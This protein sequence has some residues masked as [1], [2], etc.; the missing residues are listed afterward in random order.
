MDTRHLLFTILLCAAGLAG[1][2]EFQANVRTA[3]NQCHPAIA[4][5]ADGRC[6]L[7]WS[8]Y[9]SS[10]GRSNDIVARHF[11]PNGSPAGDELQL[12]ATRVGNQTEPAIAIGGTGCLFAAWQGPGADGDEDIFARVFDPN[13]QPLTD[14]LAVNIDPAG[15]QLYPSVAASESGTFIVVWE[16]QRV[17]EIGE[18]SSIY[19]QRFDADGMAVGDERLI[20][21]GVWDCRYPDVAMDRVGNFAVV[22]LQDRTSNT[23]RACLFDPNGRATTEP[24]DVSTADITSLTR[25]S[26][27]MRATGDF[28]VVWDGDPNLA[29]RD[30]IHARCFEPNG[31]PQ[32]EPFPVNSLHEGAQQWPQVAMGAA[33][34]FAVVWQHEHQDPNIAS[35]IF[36]RRFGLDGRPIG[37]EVKLNG[38]VAGRQRYPEAAMASDGSLIAAW[39]SDDQDGSGYG[40][41][42]CI[43]PAPPTADLNADGTVDF[44][45]FRRLG[46][47]WLASGP[48]EVGDLTGDGWVNSRD[49]EILCQHWLD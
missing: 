19:G 14:E 34:A 7:V 26:I 30:D 6:V 13:G 38:Y 10:G 9:F 11:D 28:V 4:A 17:D 15:R 20:D 18:I 43:E 33:H 39:E 45:D 27:A 40:I 23:V 31:T 42:A 24:F 46:G 21:A 1:A 37:E 41:F 12:N 5:D 8:S 32:S 25:P 16:S 36:T 44:R 35:D 48:T 29:S 47:S 49:L 3:G 22:W 2:D